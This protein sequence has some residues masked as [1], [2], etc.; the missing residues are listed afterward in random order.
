[1]TE[2]VSANGAIQQPLGQIGYHYRNC[3]GV[4]GGFERGAGTTMAVSDY[5]TLT[6]RAAVMSTG[7]VVFVGDQRPSGPAQV[8]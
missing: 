2:N 8:D 7:T 5:D 4:L 1:V 3:N 6:C